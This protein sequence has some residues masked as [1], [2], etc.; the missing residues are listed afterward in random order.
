VEKDGISTGIVAGGGG[1]GLGGEGPWSESH[2]L[3]P[4]ARFVAAAPQP[5]LLPTLAVRRTA[6]AS[7]DRLIIIWR[8]WIHTDD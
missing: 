3:Q 5:Y 6:R 1:N 8:V 2:G 7:P 4:P